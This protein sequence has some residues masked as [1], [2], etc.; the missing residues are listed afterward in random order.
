MI[1]IMQG[2]IRILNLEFKVAKKYPL[3]TRY[4][5][6]LMPLDSDDSDVIICGQLFDCSP[7]SPF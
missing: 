5:P 6:D 4:I 7:Q 1:Q 3:P 2:G